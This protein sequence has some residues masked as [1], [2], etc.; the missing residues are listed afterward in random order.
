MFPPFKRGGHEKFYPVLGGGGA[1]VQKVSDLRFSHFVGPLP[2][3]NDQS[4]PDIVK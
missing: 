3:I 4:K 1:G 2:I